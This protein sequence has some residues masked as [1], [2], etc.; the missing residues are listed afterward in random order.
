MI[1]L[2]NIKT[3]RKIWLREK[4]SNGIHSTS[5]PLG[6]IPMG[7]VLRELF[8]VGA[9]SAVTFIPFCLI[10]QYLCFF[11]F[12]LSTNFPLVSSSLAAYAASINAFI[13]VIMY[14]YYGLSA[15]GP[16]YQKYLWWKRYLTQLQLVSLTL[17]ITSANSLIMIIIIGV[18]I[19]ILSY[20]FV[21]MLRHLY[22]K[23]KTHSQVSRN[24][25]GGAM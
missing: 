10:F 5:V 6:D 17:C 11:F 16:A 13:H 15:L 8:S 25:A 20:A 23:R 1:R 7:T 18:I 9:P 12:L 22:A 14:F 4:V 21:L 2:H 19:L 3:P 24:H